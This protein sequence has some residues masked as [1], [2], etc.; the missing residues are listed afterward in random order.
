M[1]WL[2]WWCLDYARE[3]PWASWRLLTTYPKTF[4]YLG[5]VRRD[6]CVMLQAMIDAG[7]GWD[8]HCM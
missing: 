1:L 8:L 5:L 2:L 4:S 6:A 7:R 3:V